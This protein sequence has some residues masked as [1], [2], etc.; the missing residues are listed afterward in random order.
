MGLADI[1]YRN[2][3]RIDEGKC[4]GCLVCVNACPLRA[5]DGKPGSVPL[6]NENLCI[7]CG[8]CADVCPFNAIAIRKK[9]SIVP[10]F[11]LVLIVLASSLT[12]YYMIHS[13]AQS[14]SQLAEPTRTLPGSFEEPKVSM[15]NV[16]VS[17]Y[18]AMNEEA[19]TSGG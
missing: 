5:L 13:P 17:F 1:F 16:D 15:V 2:I 6:V 4:K 18:E 14:E 7:G 11:F 10:V 3:A 9:L 8:I 12:A 19:G